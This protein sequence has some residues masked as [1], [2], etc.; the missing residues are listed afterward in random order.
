[1]VYTCSVC[2]YR[3]EEQV[4]KT[5]FKDVPADYHCP[6]CNAPKDAFVETK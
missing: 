6:I 1:M 2:G 4:E 3:Y 5:A